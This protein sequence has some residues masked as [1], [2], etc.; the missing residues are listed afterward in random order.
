[1]SLKKYIILSPEGE[2][3]A[4]KHDVEVN[5]LQVM[6]IVENVS[7]EDEAII[8]LLNDN[9]WII[10]AEYNIAEFIV[11]EIISTE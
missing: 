8:K 1:M 10:D 11:Y 9:E 6:G 7:N 4:P 2:T 5:N 3:I